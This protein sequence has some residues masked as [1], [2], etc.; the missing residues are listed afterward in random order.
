VKRLLHTPD[1]RILRAAHPDYPD[2]LIT[3]Q[4]DFS[5]WGVVSWNIHKV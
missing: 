1:G 2:M 3:P 4:Q 5:V